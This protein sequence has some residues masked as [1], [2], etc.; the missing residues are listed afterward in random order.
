MQELVDTIRDEEKP[1]AVIVLSHN[2]FDVDQKMAEVCTGI[3]FIM[4]DILMMVFL[5]LFLLKMKKVLHMYV[6]LDQ[7]VNS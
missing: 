1:D 5:K 4:G 3:D 6:M 2:G 7:M